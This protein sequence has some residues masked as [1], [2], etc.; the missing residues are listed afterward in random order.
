MNNLLE[1]DE[2]ALESEKIDEADGDEGE[3]LANGS[4]LSQVEPPPNLNGNGAM[5]KGLKTE[6]CK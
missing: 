4:H 3:A 6:T 2:D 1:E 5:V